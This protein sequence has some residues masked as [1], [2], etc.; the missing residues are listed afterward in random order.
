MKINICMFRLIKSQYCE[1]FSC[2]KCSTKFQMSWST[3]YGDPLDGTHKC[4][5]PDC[6]SEFKVIV[7]TTTT[8]EV[9]E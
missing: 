3:E 4:K 1:D 5:C 8:Y 9:I 6:L 2:P 7:D